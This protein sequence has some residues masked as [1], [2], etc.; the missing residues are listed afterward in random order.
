M[1]RSAPVARESG[2]CA[3]YGLRSTLAAGA[4]DAKRAGGLVWRA[5][6]GVGGVSNSIRAFPI[7]W[8]DVSI[9]T[10]VRVRGGDGGGREV[11]I[12]GHMLVACVL[13]RGVLWPFISGVSRGLAAN[14]YSSLPILW[15]RHA[16]R[17]Q[18]PREG[19]RTA[20]A[21]CTSAF[22]T[23]WSSC[24]AVMH[25]LRRDRSGLRVWGRC[26]GGGEAKAVKGG[27]A[28]MLGSARP[29]ERGLT[30][31]ATR[32]HR[33]ACEGRGWGRGRVGLTPGARGRGHPGR[34]AREGKRCSVMCDVRKQLCPAARRKG[35]PQGSSRQQWVW[36][37]W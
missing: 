34:R 37:S 19:R 17:R 2:A 20:V 12:G 25:G 33:C 27:A 18:S 24:T 4:E 10:P 35:R 28:H 31:A 22:W 9:L 8:V 7:G 11:P 21:V 16:R 29:R 26:C 6:V 36:V 3:G 30:Q 5:R 13:V 32:V 23:F 15:H 14:A 1:G